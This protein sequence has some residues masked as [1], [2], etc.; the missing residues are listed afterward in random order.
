MMRI[1]KDGRELHYIVQHPGA[2][3]KTW[4]TESPTS[5]QRNEAASESRPPDCPNFFSMAVTKS[6]GVIPS[7]D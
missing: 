1:Y 7:L 3:L 6:E 2:A 5:P 4:D